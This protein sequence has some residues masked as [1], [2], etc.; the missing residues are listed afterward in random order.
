MVFTSWVFVGFFAVVYPVYLG[1]QRHFRAQNL[2]LLV[3]SCI[4]YG[5]WDWRFLA[6]LGGSTVV[7]YTLARW[8]D[9]TEEP[10]ARKRLVTASILMNLGVLGLFKYF[11]F[12]ADSAV[13]LL[14]TLGFSSTWTPIRVIL[15]VGV[16]FYTFQALSYT[17]EVYRKNLKATRSFVEFAVYVTF[18][19]QLVAG[20]IER[21]THLLPQVQTPRV[22]RLPEVNAG[23]SLIL[24]GFFK[25]LVIADNVARVANE[26][27]DHHRSYEGLDLVL[28]VLA[29]TLQIY[30]DFSAYTDIA[31]GL[32][33][34]LG[35]DLML[36]FR[37]PYLA[38]SPSD[39]WQRW[40]ISLSGWLRDYLYI[41][42]GGNQ[43]GAWLTY[44]NLAITMLLGGLWHGASWNFVLW[45]SF[46]GAILIVYRAL[47]AAPEREPT[48]VS[49]G[50][51]LRRFAQLG[52][53][54]TLTNIGWVLFRAT[55]VAQIAWFFTHSGVRTSGHTPG[56]AA[57]L[58]L[59]AAPL[60]LVDLAQALRGDLAVLAR[61]PTPARALVIGLLLV[62]LTAFGVRTTSEFIYF[63]F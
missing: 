19:P 29:F 53:M 52:V 4:F 21:S 35:F 58:A 37:I 51:H 61:L 38:L 6:L 23:L 39:F 25:K 18:F 42:L 11:N 30:C 41:P 12:F 45:G 50:G 48:P 31:R 34:L 44:R 15:P 57:D 40:H 54:F 27:F 33:K 24:W 16:S 9:A 43:G 14:D 3:V 7:D 59:A 62:G 10:R 1:L 49:V 46:H 2:F 36:N 63:Q 20:P 47:G 60:L 26:V 13:A 55:T 5:Y 8:I 56:F 17:I 22:V 28:G 32:A